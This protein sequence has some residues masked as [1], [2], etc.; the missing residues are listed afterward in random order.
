MNSLKLALDLSDS[1]ALLSLGSCWDPSRR[2]APLGA[3]HHGHALGW[4]SC[5]RIS[6][7]PSG[8]KSV[9]PYWVHA[10][11]GGDPDGEE[12]ITLMDEEV[13]PAIQQFL[14]RVNERRSCACRG[15][16]VG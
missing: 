16:V 8:R 9:P 10:A 14:D 15:P 3:D 2:C 13:I 6:V 7:L 11:F 1:G 4:N 5:W 12:E